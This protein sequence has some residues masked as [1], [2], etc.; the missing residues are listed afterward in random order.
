M[1]GNGFTVGIA[2]SSLNERRSRRHLSAVDAV[3]SLRLGRLR[4]LKLLLLKYLCRD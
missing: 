3:V 4:P 1:L 2:R